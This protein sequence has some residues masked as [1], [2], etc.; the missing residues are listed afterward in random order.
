M[1]IRS[2]CVCAASCAALLFSA[3]QQ[4]Q[5]EPY[6]GYKKAPYTLKGVRYVPMDVQTA[7]RY[8]ED[9]IAS[10]YEADGAR[11][12]IGQRLYE[13]QFYA[14]HRTLPL[15]CHV[16]IT[17]LSNGKSCKARVADRGPF[18]QGRLIDVS[19]AVAEELGFTRKGLERVRVEVLW[20]GD[21]KYKVRR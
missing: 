20:V 21:G 11:G 6:R 12:A 18:I 19:S 3:C 13:G 16:R 7:L 2:F 1:N 8:R 5:F 14:A 10:F 17:N 9:G 15:P 4:Q